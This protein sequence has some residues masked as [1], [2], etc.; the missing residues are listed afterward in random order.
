[1]L[2]RILKTAVFI[3]LV[4]G[5]FLSQFFV[6]VSRYLPLGQ[7]IRILEKAG[8]LAPLLFIAMMAA[9]VV[10]SPIP[11][12][13]LD[14]A[15]GAFFGPFLG[16]FYSLVGGLLGAVI[17]F[18]LAR[19][20]GRGLV[21]RFL[22]GHINFCTTCSDR[23]VAK[24]VFISRMI[25]AVS[26]DLVSYGAGL[27]KISYRWFAAATFFGMIPLTFTYNYFGSVRIEER[28]LSL[29]VGFLM[30]VL[31]FVVPWLVETYDPFGLSKYFR[32]E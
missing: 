18:S 16:T 3:T 20:F 27:T 2:G 26:F 11:S 12:L 21:E 4:A 19:F 24:I 28:G 29:V 5:L 25:P 14:I 30:V 7:I 32:H 6:D 10:V 8:S 31:F 13:P 22:R 15:G 9:A 23:L 1:M 17:A